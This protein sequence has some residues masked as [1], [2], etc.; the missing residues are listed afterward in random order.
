MR[1]EMCRLP[2]CKDLG[3]EEYGLDNC[4]WRAEMNVSS[5]VQR[6]LTFGL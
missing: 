4:G 6:D 2:S 5:S 3:G 1:I